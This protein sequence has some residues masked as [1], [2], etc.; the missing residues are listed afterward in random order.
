M[1]QAKKPNNLPA[2]VAPTGRSL[3]VIDDKNAP[4]AA[5]LPQTT[6]PAAPHVEAEFEQ[7]PPVEII[8]DAAQLKERIIEYLGAILARCWTDR[9]LLDQIA[10]DPHTTLRH[11]GILLPSEIDIKVERPNQ[12]RPRLV[13]YEWDRNRSFRR[14]ICYLQLI[15][16]AGQ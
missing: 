11:L 12:S 3:A 6:E 9:G 5:N 7:E 8:I 14:R 10:L 16:M 4:A 15:M 2:V 13:I 1:P